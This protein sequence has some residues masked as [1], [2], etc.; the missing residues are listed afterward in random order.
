[1]ASRLRAIKDGCVSVPLAYTH[2]ER[3]APLLTQ[4]GL[5]GR[6]IRTVLP[7]QRHFLIPTAAAMLRLCLF[8]RLPSCLVRI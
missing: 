3:R 5:D 8:V 4:D 2:A 1:M 7:P 6:I